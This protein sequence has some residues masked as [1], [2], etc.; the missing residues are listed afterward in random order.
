MIA[1][2]EDRS[3]AFKS[4]YKK[5]EGSTP[6]HR[7]SD[8]HLSRARQEHPQRE[9]DLEGEEVSVLARGILPFLCKPEE[10][11]TPLTIRNLDVC[12]R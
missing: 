6:P 7:R 10:V 3:L 2:L 1:S 4:F 12:L 5:L 8:A 11:V 9:D